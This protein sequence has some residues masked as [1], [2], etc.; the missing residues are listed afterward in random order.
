MSGPVAVETETNWRAGFRLYIIIIIPMVALFAFAGVLISGAWSDRK[1]ALALEDIVQAATEASTLAH[2]L[3]R[4]R[5]FS[6]G[7]I[8]ASDGQFDDLL[9]NQRRQTDAV[10]AAVFDKV[11]AAAER[12][13]G[14]YGAFARGRVAELSRSLEALTALRGQVDARSVATGDMA[15]HYTSIIV[16]LLSLSNDHLQVGG[17][18]E[19]LLANLLYNDV[20][21][22]K[23]FAGRERAA[24]A[25]G[26]GSG[27]FSHAV[28]VWYANMQDRQAALF[29]KIRTLGGDDTDA[30][31]AAALESPAAERVRALREIALGSLESG[32]LGAVT[33]P[34]WFAA[35]SAYLGELQKV[36]RAFAQK[37]I[38]LSEAKRADAMSFLAV[39]IV[40][41]LLTTLFIGLYGKSALRSMIRTMRGISQSIKAI[42]RS[43]DDVVVPGQERKDDLGIIARSLDRIGSRGAMMARVQAAVESCDSGILVLDADGRRV[44]ASACFERIMEDRAKEL[45][46]LVRTDVLENGAAVQNFSALVRAID[47]GDKIGWKTVRRNGAEAV[48]LRHGGCIFETTTT[49]ACDADGRVIGYAVEVFDVTDTRKL[50]NEVKAVIDQVHVGRFDLDIHAIDG[51]GFTSVAAKGINDLI[52]N[53]RAFMAPLQETLS[54]M[55]AGDL[56]QEMRGA[57]NGQFADVARDVNAN[58]TQFRETLAKIGDISQGVRTTAAPISTGANDLSSRAEQQAASL[59]QTATTTGEMAQVVRSNAESADEAD[60][61]SRDARESA[62]KGGQVVTQAVEAMGRIEESSNQISAIVAV[63]DSIAFQTNLL[64]LNAAVEAA[65]AG[66]S[67]KGFAVVASEVRTLAQ[68]SADAARDIKQLI[69]ASSQNVAEGAAMVRSTGAALEEICEAIAKVSDTIAEISAASRA[70]AGNIDEVSAAVSELDDATQTTAGIAERNAAA[71]RELEAQAE[72]LAELMQHFQTGVTEAQRS[73]A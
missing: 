52:S 46:D 73:A 62:E 2:E 69:D 29:D 64:A 13:D 8:G 28:L 68:R 53:V 66:E 6:A 31:L 15:R 14:A 48:E 60:A 19:L 16:G 59:R 56:S 42:E 11:V 37:I 5:G 54:A 38:T 20:L 58:L 47:E 23:E 50:E 22:A 49:K 4:E 44:V 33:G 35:S 40:A 25:N 26:F 24:G 10:R 71:A 36:E 32:D 70:Q 67:G 27:A 39:E 41:L 57:F 65:R 9:A 17:A 30:I 3:Q 61:T 72:T 43:E 18:P 51:L 45:G 7:Y 55:A 12:A 34:E 21:M 63:I 1:N